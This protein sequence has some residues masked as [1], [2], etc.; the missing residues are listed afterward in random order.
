MAQPSQ[1]VE[2][3]TPATERVRSTRTICGTGWARATTTARAVTTCSSTGTVKQ[4]RSGGTVPRGRPSGLVAAPG[5]GGTTCVVGDRDCGGAYRGR[6]G[7]AAQRQAGPCPGCRT[8]AQD[9][10]QLRSAGARGDHRRGQPPVRPQGRG[11]HDH[12]GPQIGRAHV[13]TPGT[14]AQLGS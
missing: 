8:A 7:G 14:N 11:R 4:A 1:V 2:P 12:G 3:E 5:G 6:D 13:C 10:T 9:A